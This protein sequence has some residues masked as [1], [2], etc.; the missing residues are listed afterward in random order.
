MTYEG[1]T[2]IGTSHPGLPLFMFGKTPHMT[3]AITS[4]LTDLSDMF[5]EKLSEDK[6]Q[7]FVDG[8]WKQLKVINEHIPIKGK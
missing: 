1:Q 2:T 8:Q 4:A 5:K 7:Y 6:L 3:W